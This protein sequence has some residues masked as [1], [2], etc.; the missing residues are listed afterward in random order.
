MSLSC[1]SSCLCFFIRHSDVLI[2]LADEWLCVLSDILKAKA[3]FS[4][5]LMVCFLCSS[6]LQGTVT[7]SQSQLLVE[8]TIR[9]AFGAKKLRFHIWYSDLFSL[10]FWAEIAFS[11]VPCVFVGITVFGF[12]YTNSTLIHWS[13]ASFSC[14]LP[15]LNQSCL[16][17]QVVTG[18]MTL[19]HLRLWRGFLHPKGPQNLVCQV[20]D[21]HSPFP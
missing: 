6:W 19:I 18:S 16:C 20:L 21:L 4:H 8:K 17:L 12:N 10:I 1:A 3:Y 5:Y 2:W 14:L 7:I 15:C 9:E 13:H 11:S